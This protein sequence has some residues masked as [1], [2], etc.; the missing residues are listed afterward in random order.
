MP[1][2]AK[3]GVSGCY[4]RTNDNDAVTII[5]G[6]NPHP[7]LSGR[8]LGQEPAWG[9]SLGPAGPQG[10]PGGGLEGR[11]EE[12]NG[13]AGAQGSERE[14]ARRWE[15]GGGNWGGEMGARGRRGDEAE[16]RW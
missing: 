7:E 14:G 13:E 3:S 8:V 11:E 9:R 16:T 10:H 2:R 4:H 6:P 12:L 5:T 1:E 15:W